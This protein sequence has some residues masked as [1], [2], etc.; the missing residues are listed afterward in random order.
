QFIRMKINR[1]TIA[2]M[3]LMMWATPCLLANAHVQE[4]PSLK[5][6]Y[7]KP[8]GETWENALPVGNGRLGGMVY[9]NVE[10]ETIQLNE[11]TIWSGS[12]YRN[13]T[14]LHPDSLAEIRR[15]I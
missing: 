4:Q 8:A 14:P 1:K 6:W 3:A 11:H 15:L 7:D 9:G 5:L 12:P 10:K 2:G 13:D